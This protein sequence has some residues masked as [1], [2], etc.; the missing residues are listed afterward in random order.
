ML[1][2]SQYYLCGDNEYKAWMY[3]EDNKE[4]SYRYFRRFLQV[5]GSKYRPRSQW[6]LKC[7]MHTLYLDALMKEF[8]DTRLIFT[9]R[10]P[11]NIIPSWSQFQAQMVF[12]FFHLIIYSQVI[13]SNEFFFSFFF[14]SLH[15]VSYLYWS[16]IWYYPSM[17]SRNKIYDLR[18]GTKNFKI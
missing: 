8:P 17:Y 15:L 16:R 3:R 11:E 14:F 4:Y 18:N 7:P 12:F 2:F 13:L 9:H 10:S 6:I 1:V 5:L